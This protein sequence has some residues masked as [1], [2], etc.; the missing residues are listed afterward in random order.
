MMI[1]DV[2]IQPGRVWGRG[3]EEKKNQ[4]IGYNVSDRSSLSP[5]P[6]PPLLMRFNEE[7]GLINLIPVVEAS[8]HNE[9]RQNT[10][11]GS[12]RY[13]NIGNFSNKNVITSEG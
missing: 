3:G 8:L 6:P 2:S 4:S 11:G 10:E 5:S 12:G 13:R 1:Q 9:K 7:L